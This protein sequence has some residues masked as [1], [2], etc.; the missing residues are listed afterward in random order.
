MRLHHLVSL[1]EAAH[2][3]CSLRLPQWGYH[4]EAASL[5]LPH[6]GCFTEAAS[7]RLPHFGCL[8]E[9]ASL[10][11]HH[12][13]GL[14]EHLTEAA[15][16]WLPHCNTEVVL[17]QQPHCGSLTVALFLNLHPSYIR[18]CLIVYATYLYN[19]S[20]WY[21]CL[22]VCRQQTQKLQRGSS[23]NNQRCLSYS[24]C[25][26]FV[27][28][29]VAF[30]PD[31]WWNLLDFAT[32]YTWITL[33]WVTL[34][35]LRFVLEEPNGTILMSVAPPPAL[36]ARSLICFSK[37]WTGISKLQSLQKKLPLSQ[38][39]LLDMPLIYRALKWLLQ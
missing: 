15:S 38:T 7:L 19:F 23:P 17:L 24:E 32:K 29:I 5:R 11:L 12:W 35:G 34:Q 6:W 31:Y 8:T 10:C 21:H 16:M 2:W 20:L 22:K 3:G 28:E 1:T 25:F 39:C 9:A 36:Q 4:T 13:I 14:T 18:C 33:L 30:W 26:I 37:Q 27:C